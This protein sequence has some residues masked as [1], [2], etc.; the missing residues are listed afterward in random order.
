MGESWKQ[1]FLID[2]A[3]G[4]INIGLLDEEGKA[5]I[6]FDPI[7]RVVNVDGKVI[8]RDI[9]A[10]NFIM[11][12]L[13]GKDNPAIYTQ[14][15]SWGDNNSGIWMG[16]DN[17]SAKAKL[18]IGNA[19][20]WIRYDG[21]TL[22]ISS[23]VV[24]GTP[25]GDVDIGTGLQGKQTVFVYKLATSLPAKPLEQDYPP[26]GWSKTPPNR[27]D[28]TQNIYATT[29]TLD[30]KKSPPA[31]VDGT[32]YSAAS[33]WSGVPGT[34]GTDG[35]NGDYTV[36]IYQI[37]A[38]KP[39]KPGNINDPSGW[40]RTPPTGTPLWMCSGRFNGDTNALT[41]EGWSDPIRVDGEKGDKG[42]TGP[43]GPQGPAGNSVKVQWSKDGTT[44]W[45]ATFKT[46]DM[47]MRQQVNGVWGPAIRAVGEDGN[48]GT[49]GT[50]GNYITMSFRVAATKPA[51]PTGNNPSDWSDAP[52]HGNPLWMVKAEFNG[53]TNAIIG[54]WSDPVRIDGETI[55]PNLYPVK[56]TLS[57]SGPE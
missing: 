7:N 8:T 23:G 14:G 12:N 26:P 33:Q 13:S 16:M 55:K 28:M 10:A 43:Q 31:L 6:S 52:P 51:R 49:H 24:I 35:S 30:P 4:A 47:F 32:N 54:T 3:T 1:T 41:V 44:N 19:T 11:T 57:S 9:N 53:E 22:R 27:T 34:G 29:G 45:H 2:A 17:T 25:N 56:K 40:S 21:T 38:S 15:K 36:Q 39:T 48:N 50:K 20:Q 5:P 42:D 46:G 18:D 37:S